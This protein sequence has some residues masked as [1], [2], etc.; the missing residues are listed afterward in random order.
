MI[1]R[2]IIILFLIIAMSFTF[3]TTSL[4]YEDELF[5]FDLPSNFANISYQE[6][7][8]FADTTAPQG[9]G[10]MIYAYKDTGIKKSVWDIDDLDLEMLIRR[11]GYGVNIIKKDKREKL[12]KEKAV[13]VTISESGK[14]G[15]IYILAS[16]NYVYMVMFIGDSLSDL[17]SSDYQTIKDSFELKDATTNFK[18]VYIIVSIVIIIVSFAIATKRRNKKINMNS[19]IDYKNMTEEDFNIKQ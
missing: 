13:K 18:A 4:G 2:F 7:Y 17:N 12:G 11:L 3:I 9:R 19:N 16:N 10:F 14:Y 5:K 15:E 8:M 1:K 6:F